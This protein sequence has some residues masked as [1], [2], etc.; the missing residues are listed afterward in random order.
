M[1]DFVSIWS[2]AAAATCCVALGLRANLLKP[3]VSICDAPTGVWI[4]LIVLS[5]ICGGAAVSLV[6]GER[7]IKGTY[8][9]AVVYTALAVS[10]VI[11]LFN[12]MRQVWSRNRPAPPQ[13]N[14]SWDGRHDKM[15]KHHAVR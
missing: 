5:M 11:M 3:K 1:I 4:S 9:E 6:F 15:V 14:G 2:A 10:S 12:L 13:P 8:R 7:I